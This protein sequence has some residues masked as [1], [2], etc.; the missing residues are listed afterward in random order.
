MKYLLNHCNRQLKMSILCLTFLL[1]S[2]LL[3]IIL[4]ETVHHEIVSRFQSNVI[5]RLRQPNQNIIANGQVFFD[6]DRKL[7]QMNIKPLNIKNATSMALMTKKAPGVSLLTKRL[8]YCVRINRIR[9][10]R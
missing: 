10:M 6:F 9:Y 3:Q 8:L 2:C 7:F 4:T 1:S 5:V